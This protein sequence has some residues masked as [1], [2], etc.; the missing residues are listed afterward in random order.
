MH[1]S[2]THLRILRFLEARIM[3]ATDEE[4]SLDLGIPANSLRP[5]RHE[6][7]L[8]G[9]AKA[10]DNQRLTFGGSPAVVWVACDQEPGAQPPRSRSSRIAEAAGPLVVKA[11]DLVERFPHLEDGV[12]MRLTVTMRDLRHLVTAAGEQ[13]G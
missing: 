11:E 3:G 9:R 7:V 13:H 10:S 4:M 5:R 8:A 2:P 12:A 1:L 6:L